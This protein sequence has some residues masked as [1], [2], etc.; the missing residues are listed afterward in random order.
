VVGQRC[1]DRG[2]PLGRPGHDRTPVGWRRLHR[3]G[4]A[5]VAGDGA[6]VDSGLEDGAQVGEH[7]ADVARRELL[8]EPARPCL[9]DTRPER[10]QRVVAEVR[11]DVQPKPE[12][13]GLTGCLV[14]GL[15]GQARVT[16]SA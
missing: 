12:R 7:D 10:R 4:P 5:R 14:K 11:V 16:V 1:G 2:D 6:V 3:P 8:L 15:D 13:D 9:D